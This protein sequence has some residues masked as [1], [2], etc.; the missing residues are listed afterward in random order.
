MGGATS[1]SGGHPS[2]PADSGSLRTRRAPVTSPSAAHHS[3]PATGIIL[4]VRRGAP[5]PC[6]KA[7]SLRRR[8]GQATGAGNE[9]CVSYCGSTLRTGWQEVGAALVSSTLLSHSTMISS[10]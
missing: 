7:P 8:Q 5:P 1:L 4:P 10:D 3:A 2:I 9:R 6:C